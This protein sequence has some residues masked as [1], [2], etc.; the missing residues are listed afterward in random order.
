MKNNIN[1][2]SKNGFLKIVLA[3]SFLLTPFQGVQAAVL[4]STCIDL[5]SELNLRNIRVRSE[6]DQRRITE[7][8]LDEKVVKS[9]PLIPEFSYIRETAQKMGLRVWLFGG[10]ASSFLHYAKWDLL[11]QKGLMDLQKDRFDYDFTNIFRSTQDLDIVVD[12]SPDVARQFQTIIAQKYPHFLGSKANKWEVRTLK[13]R[14]GTPGQ[15][16]FKEALLNDN[17]F[18]N[19]NTDS[20]SIGMVE[21]SL[22]HDPVIRD[23]RHW[24]DTESVFLD[25]TLENRIS[26]FRSAKHFTTSRAKNGENPEILSVLRL[27]VK[28]FQYELN[29]SNQDFL[30]MK[31]VA[32][33][34][35]PKKTSN[36]AALRR[37]ADTAKKLVIHAVN[38]EYAINKL[39]E[40]G[41]RQ[42]LIAMGN[43]DEQGSFAWWINREPLRSKSVGQGRGKTAKDLNIQVVAHETTSFLAY[44]S[45]TRSHSGEPNVLISRQNAVGEA[46]A[47]G[48]GF[49]T[50][51]GKIGARGT[52]LTI[53]FTVDS[54]A[55]EGSDFT[56]NG[57]YI[58]FKNKSALKVIQESLNFGLDD[59]LKLAETN[60]EV[61][62][63]QSDLALLEKLK[64][65]L[66]AS[67]IT[68]ELE[69]LLNSSQDK[70]HDRLVQILSA[71]Q[72]SAVSKLIS[73]DVLA[74]VVKN[75]YGR[76]S[77][78]AQSSN[79]A[80]VLRYIR[81]VGPIIK[82]V[83]SVGLLKTSTFVDY[84]DG[85][86]RSPTSSFELRKEAV[87]EILL[88]SQDT[89]NFEN[90][91]NFKRDLS[92]EELQVVAR[93]IKEWGNS[94]DARKRRFAGELDNRWLKA[95]ENGDIKKIQALIDSRF[96][97]LNYK[98]ISG[99]SLLLL[100]D[101]YDQKNIIDW[102]IQNP[103][104][105]FNKK[106]NLGL[107]EVEQLRLLG[108]NKLADQ[109]Q[110]ARLDVVARRFNV[111]ER[112]DDG[113]PIIDFVRIEPASFMMGDGDSKVLTTVTKP[114]GILSTK[115]TQKQW[116]GVVELLKKYRGN[117][118]NVLSDSPSNF[119]GEM[120]PVEQISFDD[121]TLWNKGLNEL[122]QIDNDQIQEK[123]KVLFPGHQRGAQYGRP[124][125]A[126]WELVA[127]NGGLAQGGYAFGNSE[128]NLGDHAYFSGNSGSKS[129]PVG[130]KRPI[131]YNGKPI[132][133]MHG[134]VWEWTDDWYGQNISGGKDP[135]GPSSGSHRVVRVGSSRVD[136]QACK[137]EYS[138]VSPK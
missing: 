40:L 19:Q 10:T 117:S 32:N 13:S 105:D 30:Q 33:E 52:G 113:S 107:T 63:D 7:K 4:S 24:N 8:E 92:E 62:V 128:K 125:D 73:P 120:N 135:A 22:S 48:D 28:A 18:N 45:I 29:F 104:F 121:I 71:F 43:K 130:E 72:N 77:Y 12:A 100:A 21:L 25:D 78:L 3:A 96:F 129:H 20:N 111:K 84:L 110:Q 103:N 138:I 83:D 36:S 76:V 94:S 75:I 102:L 67:K 90:H 99:H 55:R 131:F 74:S 64:R 108:K 132:Y 6:V 98:N 134:L 112:N 136:L 85:L 5:L 9:I 122:S 57:D 2:L 119:K 15:P 38:I 59:L 79:E 115:T 26:F 11:R 80:E 35:N 95:I 124:T 69:K 137:L 49:Y 16:G 58:V 42:K 106:N 53:R 65:R 93:E 41:L 82:T 46:A 101:Y 50:R 17:D 54:A 66:N 126:Q 118:Y 88:A 116:R 86:S 123:L 97:D 23:L 56:V 127:R 47:F 34:F 91:L 61:Q 31:E 1:A 44:E 37:I 39:D 89:L 114:F 109:I 68:D 60:Q 51:L 27:L 87:F 133:D 70:D 81:T 14:M